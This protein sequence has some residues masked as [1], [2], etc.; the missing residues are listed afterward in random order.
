MLTERVKLNLSPLKAGVSAVALAAAV[1]TC[2]PLMFPES[3]GTYAFAQEGTGGHGGQGQGGQGQGG[4][5]GQGGH[6]D[7]GH[8]DE[9]H[10]DGGGSGGHAGGAGGSGQGGPDADSEG[11]GPAYGQ[12]SGSQG[13]RPVWAQEGIPD[14]ELGRLNVARSPDRVLDQALAEALNNF[15]PELAAFYSLSIEEAIAV[16]TTNFDNVVMIDSPLENLGLLRDVL[17]GTSSLT[18]LGVV[19]SPETLAAMFLGTAS[20][21]TIEITPETAY[22]VAA[23]LGFELTDAQ[24]T[25]LAED[26]EAIR[27][28]ILEGHG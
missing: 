16:L 23:I 10:T 28:A 22:A 15:T 27:E 2:A 6:T 17:D 26:A 12:P 25:E 24:A 18:A 8:T 20:D 3:L 19:N 21:K 7:G 11:R 9:G 4:Q 5:G 1:F 13:G 14:V